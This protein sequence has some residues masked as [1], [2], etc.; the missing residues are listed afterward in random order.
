MRL[1]RAVKDLQTKYDSLQAEMNRERDS[2]AIQVKEHQSRVA[3]LDAQLAEQATQRKQV[4]VALLRRKTCVRPHAH[5]VLRQ[6]ADQLVASE[7]TVA[8]LRSANQ[9]LEQQVRLLSAS[10]TDLDGDLSS[11]Q[12][13]R[14][15]V[16]SAVSPCHV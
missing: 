14:Q 8:Q 3:A 16:L 9:K 2:R 10:K 5:L 6:T 12:Q 1:E 4:R 11:L 13:L 7:D 15:Q